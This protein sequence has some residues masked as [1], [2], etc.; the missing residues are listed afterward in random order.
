MNY[1]KSIILVIICMLLLSGCMLSVAKETITISVE[2]PSSAL[3]YKQYGDAFTQKYPHIRINVVT[4][5]EAAVGTDDVDLRFMSGLGQYKELS[6]NKKLLNIETFREKEASFFENISPVILN[7]LRNQSESG[8]YGLAPSFISYAI[9]YNKDLFNQYGVPF[10]KNQM[11]WSEIWDLA[12][13]FTLHSE[14]EKKIYGFKSNYYENI[15]ISL[16]WRSGQTEGLS[17]I[18]PRTLKISMNSESWKAIWTQVIDA[19][20]VKAIYD[21]PEKT[22][23]D[24]V[25]AP[26]LTGETAMEI[27]SHAAAYNFESYAQMYGKQQVNWGMVTV[28]VNSSNPA[29]SDYY[30]FEEIYG[31]SATSK[32]KEEAWQ[33]IKFITTRDLQNESYSGIPAQI[34]LLKTIKEHDLSPLYTLKPIQQSNNPYEVIDDKILAALKEIGQQIVDDAVKGKIT[35]DEALKQFEEKGQQTIIEIKEKL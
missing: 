8:L 3:F 35:I 10:P 24:F 31:I 6:K 2:H 20:K 13:H 12:K 21:I 1:N 11:T 25:P 16:I 15:G 26:I 9:Y 14:N 5:S 4:Q 19:I 22:D 30:Q 27:Q 32:H 7:S 17:F 28:P 18:D 33:L 23:G 29:Y 34:N